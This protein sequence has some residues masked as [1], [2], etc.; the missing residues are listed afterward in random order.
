VEYVY[1]TASPGLIKW[2]AI[3]LASI[4]LGLLLWDYPTPAALPAAEEFI[5][6]VGAFTI[7][8]SLLLLLCYCDGVHRTLRCGNLI[9]WIFLVLAV[10]WLIAGAVETWV[11]FI[12]NDNGSRY[13]GQRA[14]ISALSF[15]N[16]LLFLIGMQQTRVVDIY[17]PQ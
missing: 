2:L 12:Y 13:V 10:M 8:F 7:G 14:T 1:C 4:I 15:V 6:F 16:G 3:I 17:L 5:L 11:T 9:A